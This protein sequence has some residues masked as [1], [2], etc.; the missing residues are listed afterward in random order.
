MVR[1]PVFF[2]QG[3]VDGKSALDDL[4][5]GLN[6]TDDLDQR[7]EMRLVERVTNDEALG[8]LAARL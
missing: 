5:C 8:M 2:A 6:A 3:S 4:G 7:H 1:L